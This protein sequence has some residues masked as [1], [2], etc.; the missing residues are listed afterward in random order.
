[1]KVIYTLFLSG[2]FFL[3]SLSVQA[4]PVNINQADAKTIASSLK[5]IG[6]RK[7]QAIVE[8]RKKNGSFKSADDL[9]NVKGIGKKTIEKNRQDIL[10]SKL[11]HKSTK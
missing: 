9:T 5:G 11:T 7:A 6:I 3:F 4:E 1:M 8:Y 2:F 10:L